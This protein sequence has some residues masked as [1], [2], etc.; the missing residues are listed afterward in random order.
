MSGASLATSQ[1]WTR[2]RVGVLTALMSLGAGLVARRAVQLGLDASPLLREMAEEQALREVRLSPRRGSI[3]DRH[4]APLAVS[5]DVESVWADPRTLR[6]AGVEPAAAAARLA[7]V[8]D[9]VDAAALARRLASDRSFVWVARRVTPREADAVR[10]LRIPGVAMQ[11][12]ARRYYPHRELAAHVL[13]YADVDGI[14]LDGLELTYD[15]RLRGSTR[16]VRVL[17]DRTGRVV[18]GEPWLDERS[19]RGDDLELTLDRT[20]QHAAERELGLAVQT[21]EARAGSVVVL[22]PHT[23]EL[24]AMASRPTFNP[25]EPGAAPLSA[26]RNRA[27]GERFEPGSTIKP[28]TVAGALAAGVI[29]A[30]TPIDCGGGRLQVADHVLHDARRFD[31]LRPAQI[32]QYSSNVGT[33]RIGAALGRERLYETLRAFG[34]G[35]RTG[36]ALPGEAAG[37]L[38]HP[39]TW[40]DVDAA[41]IAFGQGMSATTLQLALAMAV[42]ANG[43]E[44]LEPVLVRRI[45]APD[46]T[47]VET[48]ERRVRRRVLPRS[49]ARQVA[50]MLVAVTGPE[51]TGSQAAV[52]GHLVAGKTGTA[53][54]ADE[55]AGGY[56]EGA[57]VVSF[58]GF[59]P[60]DRPRV[61]I[62]VVLDEPVVLASGGGAA[63]PVF[64]R[65]AEVALRQL[66]VPVGRLDDRPTDAGRAMPRGAAQQA[67]DGSTPPL[68]AVRHASRDPEGRSTVPDVVG[69]GA[70]TA[71]R[72]LLAAGLEASLRGVGRVVA[73]QP[74]AGA[75]VPRGT[76]VVL[77][78]REPVEASPVTI[79]GPLP[80]GESRSSQAAVSP[81]HEVGAR[82]RGEPSGPAGRSLPRERERP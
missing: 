8:L 54:K 18:F 22:D 78:L 82:A 21:L 31:V 79:H 81:P 11:R 27:V 69:R 7:S 41:T 56:R 34:F 49:V 24:L 77:T 75:D 15:A 73:Q 16:T 23:G 64:R 53:Q 58:V 80:S 13:G 40:Y 62:A 28:F 10:A 65:I 1:R 61:V 35:A 71:M 45:R 2:V 38:R 51:G 63:G 70:R 76:R 55:V 25:N 12:E 9:G 44:L 50:D 29:E 5:V 20:I 14:G 67:A 57:W 52:E 42:I 48:A 19:L 46:G 47:V 43:G 4:G 66:G 39:R 36:I 17:R 60:A 74:E 33:A 30:D 3:V 32:L 59:V 6:E 26:R 37:T 68:E 72:M